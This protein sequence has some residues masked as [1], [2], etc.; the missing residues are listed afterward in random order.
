M[1][2]LL[3]QGIAAVKGLPPERQ[4]LAGEVLLRLAAELPQ[5]TLGEHD[6]EDLKKS[7]AEADAGT[8]AS[9]EEIAEAWAKFGL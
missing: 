5:Y 8:F 9:E 2:K 6:I 4:D 7:I 1:T 3:E